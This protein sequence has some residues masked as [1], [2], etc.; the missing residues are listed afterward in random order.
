MACTKRQQTGTC[1]HHQCPVPY[2]TEHGFECVDIIDG[3]CEVGEDCIPQCPYS[4]KKGTVLFIP[5]ELPDDNL[6]RR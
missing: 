5:V 3:T 2:W 1:T 4:Y 6:D